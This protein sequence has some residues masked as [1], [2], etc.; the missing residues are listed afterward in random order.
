MTED[1]EEVSEDTMVTSNDTLARN[2]DKSIEQS[3]GVNVINQNNIDD[4][5]MMKN[6]LSL[7][8]QKSQVNNNS[9]DRHSEEVKVDGEVLEEGDDE[10]DFDVV[11]ES[12]EGQCRP[13]VLLDFSRIPQE[14][15]DVRKFNYDVILGF[16]S[17]GKLHTLHSLHSVLALLTLRALLALLAHLALLALLTILALLA[18]ISQPTI[19]FP[20]WDLVHKELQTGSPVIYYSS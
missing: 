11:V 9:V 15:L 3:N 4:N 6:L 7:T 8:K 16:V 2:G 13:G 19:L 10:E 20:A 5:V 12:E 17:K 14:E 18:H 1:V